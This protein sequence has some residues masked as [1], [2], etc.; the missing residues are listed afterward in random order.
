MPTAFTGSVCCVKATDAVASRV[1]HRRLIIPWCRDSMQDKCRVWEEEVGYKISLGCYKLRTDVD[2]FIC[3]ESCAS[4]ST[5]SAENIFQ[6][7]DLMT[8]CA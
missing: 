1:V 3:L 5:T 6:H 2:S 7:H 8:V 4:V